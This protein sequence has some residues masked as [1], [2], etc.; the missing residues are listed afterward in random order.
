MQELSHGLELQARLAPQALYGPRLRLSAEAAQRGELAFLLA[1][2]GQTL[3]HLPE[4]GGGDRPIA[5]VQTWVR[6]RVVLLACCRRR[7]RVTAPFLYTVT[8]SSSRPSHSA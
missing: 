4:A 2:I 8:A 1:H 7:I 6:H 5:G 3:A